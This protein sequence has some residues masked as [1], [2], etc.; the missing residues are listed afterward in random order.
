MQSLLLDRTT[1][2]LCLDANGNLAICTEP[3]AISQ[4]VATGIRIFVGEVWYD[5]SQGLPYRQQI[6]GRNQSAP[7]FKA[8]A[9]QVANAVPGVASSTCVINTITATR[10]IGGQ[11]QIKTTSGEVL[12]VGF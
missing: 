10:R 4:D 8:Q 11:I 3:Y 9:E 2:D 1:W 6:L 7:L 5:T 12:S